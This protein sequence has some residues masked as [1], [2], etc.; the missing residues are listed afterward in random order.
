MRL[1]Y[2][3]LAAVPAVV[4]GFAF[5]GHPVAAFAAGSAGLAGL[6]FFG[7]AEL[8]DW[9]DQTWGFAKQILPLLFGGVLAAGF[10]LGS[11]DSKDAGIVPNVWIQAL[12]GDSPPALLSM[13]GRP[14]G[15]H[16]RMVG[17]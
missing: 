16:V 11:P 2:I 4:L 13:L 5:P 9:R 12:V 1:A 6:T 8:K 14:D 15:T 7:G 3:A 17:R 10:F